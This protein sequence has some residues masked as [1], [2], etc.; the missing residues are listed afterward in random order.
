[1]NEKHI[2]VSWAHADRRLKL[3]LMDHLRPN[4]TILKSIDP[5]W[6]DDTDIP[7]GVGWRESIAARIARCDLGLHL[8][9]P[10]FLASPFIMSEEVPPFY[11]ENP[12]KAGIPVGLSPIELDP[13]VVDAGGVVDFQIFRLEG[14]FF[15][16]LRASGREE[17]GRQLAL[18]IRNRVLQIDP[19]ALAP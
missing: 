13:T 12:T 4:L 6:W 15:S 7:V 8:L 1:M 10:N 3:A 14:K 9:S 11:G 16:Q 2:F 18:S 17:F 5:R 19:W